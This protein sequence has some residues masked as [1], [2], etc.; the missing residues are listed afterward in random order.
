[1]R[2]P[3]LATGLAAILVATTVEWFLLWWRPRFYYRFAFPLGLEP[4]PIPSAPEGSGET[5]TVAWTVVDDEVLYWAMPGS[6]R[7]LP[8]LHGVVK[9]VPDRDRLRL[10]V[11]WAPPWSFVVLAA[12]V[13][14]GGATM[15]FA[16]VGGVSAALV[17]AAVVMVYNQAAIRAAAEL[18]WAFVSPLDE[19]RVG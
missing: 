13:G 16:M 19:P 12:C 1:M 5:A 6:G 2:Y 7:G 4:L 10:V 11:R 9:L 14:V 18:R 3:L 8:G 17:L 15:G